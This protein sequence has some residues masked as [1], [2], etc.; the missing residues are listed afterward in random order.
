MAIPPRSLFH[1]LERLEVLRLL[2]PLEALA[3]PVLVMCR[4]RVARS[5]ELAIPGTGGPQLHRQD[6]LR[7]RVERI[8]R[9]GIVPRLVDQSVS[10]RVEIDVR[11]GHRQLPLVADRPGVVALLEQLAARFPFSVPN[12]R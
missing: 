9:P 10:N 5:A 2:I 3:D 4:P 6:R 12:L 1:S 7:P 11:G 8:R